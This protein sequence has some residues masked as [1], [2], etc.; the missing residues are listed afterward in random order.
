MSYVLNLEFI[1]LQ[2]LSL[3]LYNMQGTRVKATSFWVVEGDSDH[4]WWLI[5]VSSFYLLLTICVNILE[6]LTFILLTVC[7]IHLLQVKSWTRLLLIIVQLWLVQLYRELHTRILWDAFYW[8]TYSYCFPCNC[9]GTALLP[10]VENVSD[11]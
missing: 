3:H 2:G 8:S 6:R 10:P 1:F 5:K 9:Q 4:L 7:S 11:M